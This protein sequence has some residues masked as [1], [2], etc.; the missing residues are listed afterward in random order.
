MPLFSD[1]LDA[2]SGTQYFSTL[3]LKSGYWQIELYPSAREKT[4]FVTHNGLYEF[5]VMPFGL[6]NSG[7]SFQRIMRHILRSLEYRYALIYVDDII[8]FSKSVDEHLAHLEEVFKR[9]R[10][11]N[12]KLNPKKCNMSS[13]K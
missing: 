8:I 4:A 1:T 12:I 9:L 11:A 10:E 13:R 6:T 5:L 3:D 2:L 7:A